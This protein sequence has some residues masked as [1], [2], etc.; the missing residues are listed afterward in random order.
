[1]SEPIEVPA[2]TKAL[3]CRG[4][5]QAGEPCSVPPSMVFENGY[6]I[7]HS[8]R[9]EHRLMKADAV[10]RGGAEMRPR[11]DPQALNPELGTVRQ[12]IGRFEQVAGD[13]RRGV[14]S[15]NQALV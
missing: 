12:I 9:A 11:P 2:A 1:M 14:L 3:A 6:C 10:L 13:H 5:T 15:D 7:S 4:T 8:P